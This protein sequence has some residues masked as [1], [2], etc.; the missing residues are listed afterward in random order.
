MYST[1]SSA[2]HSIVHAMLS[3]CLMC[4][5]LSAVIDASASL[6]QVAGCLAACQGLLQ[7]MNAADLTWDDVAT[8]YAMEDSLREGVLQAAGRVVVDKLRGRYLC[9]EEAC[10]DPEAIEAFLQL[11]LGAVEALAAMDDLQVASE[12]TV[13]TALAAWLAAHPGR[14]DAASLLLQ[15]LRLHHLTQAYVGDALLRLPGIGKH[16]TMQRLAA[17]LQYRAAK[18]CIKGAETT[19]K[20]ARPA[21]SSRFCFEWQVPV[22]DV[23]RLF[24]SYAYGGSSIFSKSLLTSPVHMYNGLT[25]VAY[26]G[27]LLDDGN[28]DLLF[29]CVAAG[30]RTGDTTT[31][32]S[33]TVPPLTSLHIDGSV[34]LA[35]SDSSTEH[36]LQ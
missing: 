5:I 20:P 13:A 14:E 32:S 11:P 1:T 31:S 12:N 30:A 36:T 26:L 28:Q 35:W 10:R 16:V 17:A 27:I 6:L 15:H 33:Y 22:A 25:W 3:I 7:A 18:S 29:A 34:E 4:T 23:N 21:P 19:L 8:F 2:I 24:H 9:L